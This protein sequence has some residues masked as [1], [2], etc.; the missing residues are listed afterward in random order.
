MVR[1]SAEREFHDAGQEQ[2]KARAPNYYCS[3][4]CLMEPWT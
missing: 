4:W 3:F 2:E 1:S